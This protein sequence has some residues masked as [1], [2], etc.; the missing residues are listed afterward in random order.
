MPDRFEF[1]RG[2]SAPAAKAVAVTPHDSNELADVTRA[3][4]VGGAGNAVVQ[5]GD[6]SATVT[7]TGL[8]AGAVYPFR[9]RKVLSTGTTATAIV[10]LY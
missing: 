7:L 2:V 10:G 8:Q 9:V 3:L 6:D 5:F 4:Y 1:S